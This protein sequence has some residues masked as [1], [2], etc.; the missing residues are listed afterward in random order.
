MNKYLLRVVYD[1]TAANALASEGWELVN[2]VEDRL[3]RFCYFFKRV[4]SPL[5]Q[6]P[7][8]E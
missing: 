2:V 3:N 7:N 5:T 6:K 1:W 4:D 8:Q